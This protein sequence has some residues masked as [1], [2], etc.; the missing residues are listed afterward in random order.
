MHT[1]AIGKGMSLD[2]RGKF[3]FSGGFGRIAFGY[4]RFG[5]YSWYA[6]VYQKKYY[7]GKPYI[8]RQKFNWGSNPQTEFQQLWRAQV[9]SGWVAWFALTSDQKWQ[10]RDRAKNLT[11]TGANLFM[12]EWLNAHKDVLT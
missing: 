12:R 2:A 1:G 10:Y 8:S 5:F 3:G 9:A 4:N 7:F 6:G 11:M